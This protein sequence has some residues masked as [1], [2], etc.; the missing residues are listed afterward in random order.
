MRPPCA[1]SPPACER[2]AVPH[3]RCGPPVRFRG[4]DRIQGAH[5][6]RERAGVAGQAGDVVPALAAHLSMHPGVTLDHAHAPQARPGAG[7][8]EVGDGGR[9]GDRPVAPHFQPAM[10][11]V[12]G[13]VLIFAEVGHARALGRG[14]ACLHVLMERALI[15]R[16]RR[17]GTGLLCHNRARDR[18]PA[19]HRS[20]GDD[21]ALQGQHL[22]QDGQRRTLAQLLRDRHLAHEQSGGRGPGAD[23]MQRSCARR[24]V[25]GA[26]HPLAIEGDHLPRC[27]HRAGGYPGLDPPGTS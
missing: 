6:R 13:D 1:P 21:S 23:Q 25:M 20:D 27:L 11:R 7:R 18:P 24:A 15:A 16:E 19:A 4:A 12:H 26:A 2:A 3:R 9:I 22:E 8:I 10:A 17:H 14:D 5:R